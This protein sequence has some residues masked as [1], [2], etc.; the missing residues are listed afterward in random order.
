MTSNKSSATTGKPPAGKSTENAPQG[1]RKGLT[2]Q[3][4]SALAMLAAGTTLSAVGFAVPPLGE[5]SDSVLWLFSQC[6]L[7]A[8]SIFGVGSYVDSKIKEMK[9]S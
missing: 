9:G 5:I 8:G 2:A 3:T 1:S 7:Y 6:L 4:A